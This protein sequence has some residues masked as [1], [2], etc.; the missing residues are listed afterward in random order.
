MDKKAA[1]NLPKTT[2]I[3]VRM[4]LLLVEKMPPPSLNGERADFI[5]DAV[6]EKLESEG[7][8]DS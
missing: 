8:F 4:P 1:E 3:T 7:A 5:R 2:L 6:F